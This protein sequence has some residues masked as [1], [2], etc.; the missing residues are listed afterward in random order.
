MDYTKIKYSKKQLN[1]ANLS[2]PD[3]Y[4]LTLPNT[5]LR[6][7]V[8]ISTPQAKDY[9]VKD[10]QFEDRVKAL[11]LERADKNE[12]NQNIIIISEISKIAEKSSKNYSDE[13]RDKPSLKV[14][15]NKNEVRPLTIL[16]IN[17]KI[18]PE[19][20]LRLCSGQDNQT[21]IGWLAYLRPYNDNLLC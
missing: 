1:W 16:K 11:V 19:I 18:I 14:C 9:G 12:V 3:T 4:P 5:D 7:K 17:L 2:P 8:F 20:M 15:L 13:P 10:V 6:L 21:L